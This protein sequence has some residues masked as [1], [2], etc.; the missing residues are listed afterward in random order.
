MRASM[1]AMVNCRKISAPLGGTFAPLAKGRVI[2]AQLTIDFQFGIHGDL[3]GSGIADSDIL[4]FQTTLSGNVT[5]AGCAFGM[6]SIFKLEMTVGCM[7]SSSSFTSTV[8]FL[9]L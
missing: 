6:G 5:A 8:A 9:E 4:P 7:A 1:E 2:G 3:Q